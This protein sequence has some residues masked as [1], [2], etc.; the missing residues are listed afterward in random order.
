MRFPLPSQQVKCAFEE[1]SFVR[2]PTIS[3]TMLA[4]ED[5]HLAP[6]GLAQLRPAREG[7]DAALKGDAERALVVKRRL[8][9]DEHVAAVSGDSLQHFS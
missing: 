4:L 7:L 9:G 6:Y 2:V 3:L 8:A 5:A 1:R